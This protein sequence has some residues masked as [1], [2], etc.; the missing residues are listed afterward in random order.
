[1]DAMLHHLGSSLGLGGVATWSL[2]TTAAAFNYLVGLAEFAVTN[3]ARDH[4]DFEA[5]AASLLHTSRQLYIDGR[6]HTS[7]GSNP[8]GRFS[9]WAEWANTTLVMHVVAPMNFSLTTLLLPDGR[10]RLETTRGDLA[11]LF[12]RIGG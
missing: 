6:L 2:Q 9:Y 1:M 10:M 3:Q 4:A 5:N 12:T 7:V 8:L 11:F